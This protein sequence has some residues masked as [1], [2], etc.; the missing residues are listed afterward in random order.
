M[1][2]SRATSSSEW[3]FWSFSC[4]GNMNYAYFSVLTWVMACYQNSEIESFTLVWLLRTQ[5]LKLFYFG[6][7]IMYYL[8]WRCSVLIV[9]LYHCR[10]MGGYLHIPVLSGLSQLMLKAWHGIHILITHLWCVLHHFILGH[11]TKVLSFCFS[12]KQRKQGG[13]SSLCH[14]F[15]IDKLNFCLASL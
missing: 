13:E 3:I 6:L 9:I 7:G 5:T 11:L 15:V 14:K 1:E 10:R 8:L 12:C 4:H 2:S